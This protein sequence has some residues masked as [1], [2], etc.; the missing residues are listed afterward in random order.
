MSAGG[1]LV[2]SGTDFTSVGTINANSNINALGHVRSGNWLYCNGSTGF[3]NETYGGGMYMQDTTWVRAYNG[4]AIWSDSA[5]RGAYIQAASGFTTENI[6]AGLVGIYSATAYQEVFSMGAAYR[7]A[8]DG[9]AVNNS[10]GILWTHSNVGGISIN[11]L[12][13]QA[14]THVVSCIYIPPP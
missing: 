6:G 1:G 14:L 7:P 4:K 13:H 5:V 2:W 10:Y 8:V 3:Y 9:S 11:G 12:E